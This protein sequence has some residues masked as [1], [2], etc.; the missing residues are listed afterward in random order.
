MERES[1][2]I[3]MDGKRIC[4][5]RCSFCEHVQLPDGYT[6][7][8]G[9]PTDENC[10]RFSAAPDIRRRVEEIFEKLPDGAGAEL[11]AVD[12]TICLADGQ[13]TGRG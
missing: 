7:A 9:L 3:Q 13:R 10:P 6:C 4:V 8:L 11:S 5:I 1:M 12:N 2:G